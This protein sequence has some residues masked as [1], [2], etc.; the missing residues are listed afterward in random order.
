MARSISK[1]ARRKWTGSC[2][3]A[4]SLHPGPVQ[5][6]NISPGNMGELR[7]DKLNCITCAAQ[8]TTSFFNYEKLDVESFAIV[9]HWSDMKKGHNFD[10]LT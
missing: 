10:K 2:L 6:E 8:A 5:K 4:K 1:T 7:K 3:T 9:Q